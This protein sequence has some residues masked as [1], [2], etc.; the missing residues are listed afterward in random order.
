MA[1]AFDASYESASGTTGSASQASFSWLHAPAGTP[2]GVLV[3]TFTNANADDATSVTYGGSSLT[4]VAGGRAVDTAGEP[5]DCKAWFLG[6]GVPTGTQTVTVNRN[7]NA[8]VMYAVS[9]TVTSS[10]NS[11][12]NTGGIVL[13]QE[14]GTIP[15]GQYVTDGGTGT[16]NS[17]RF[18]AINCGA[19]DFAT[20]LGK[21]NP[22][23][24]FPDGNSTWIHGIDY[25]TRV[26]GV[27]RETT[28]GVGFRPVGFFGP[29][30]DRAAVHLAIRD[31]A[32]AAAKVVK[33]MI[34]LGILPFAR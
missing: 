9:V 33:D 23:T 14:D 11:E 32:G 7:N 6:T 8:N 20:V 18:A 17:L 26:C 5:G 31:V 4:A 16:G 21:P 22:T 27:V 25:G 19:D 12:V 34:G 24:L 13:V 1:I 15:S 3:F 28:A 10:Q 30:E 29:T 2:K